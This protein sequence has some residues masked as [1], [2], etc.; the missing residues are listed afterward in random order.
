M[1]DFAILLL[2]PI[3]K[4]RTV[5]SHRWI[6]MATTIVAAI[7]SGV[8]SAYST[9]VP[10]HLE[11]KV[12]YVDDGDT[13]VM[14]QPNLSR[15][16]VRLSDIDAPEISHSTGRPGQPYSDL[17]RRSLSELAKG[18]FAAATCYE[19]DRWQRS[20]CTVFVNGIDVNAE[21]LKRGMVWVNRANRR[22]V[23][24]RQSYTLEA[25]AKSGAVGLWSAMQ[26][27][28]VAPWIW[29]HQ[30]WKLQLCEGAGQ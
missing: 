8:A 7:F 10:W 1:R 12:V 3:R 24:N 14:L 9:E 30:C 25:Q 26:P 15:V 4:V 19:T 2:L 16:T 20:V 11:G 27:T 23:R 5:S 6:Y 21:Q 29:R 18:Q 13:L 22:Y 28:P 17:S